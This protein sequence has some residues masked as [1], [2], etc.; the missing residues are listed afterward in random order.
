[1]EGDRFR[2]IQDFDESG[3]LREVSGLCVAQLPDSTICKTV[4]HIDAGEGEENVRH[5]SRGYCIKMDEES[6]QYE[7]QIR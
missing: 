1:M 7:G 3:A 4:R 2:Y 6:K 5:R